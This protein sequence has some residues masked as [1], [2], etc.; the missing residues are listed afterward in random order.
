MNILITGST[1]TIGRSIV[2]EFAP[3]NSLFLLYRNST[4]DDLSKIKENA[5]SLGSN[6]VTLINGE[7]GELLKNFPNEIVNINFDLFIN[8]ASSTSTLNDDDL[9]FQKKFVHRVNELYH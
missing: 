6:S 3:N 8:V 2:K 1:S 4:K 7:L 9:F 5:L